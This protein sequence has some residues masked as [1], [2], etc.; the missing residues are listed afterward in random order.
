MSILST[1]NDKNFATYVVAFQVPDGSHIIHRYKDIPVV[2]RDQSAI[3]LQPGEV[4]LN[5]QFYTMETVL[6]EAFDKT[7]TTKAIS[8]VSYNQHVGYELSKDEAIA[9][10]DSKEYNGIELIPGFADRADFLVKI[11]MPTE[12]FF[13]NPLGEIYIKAPHQTTASPVAEPGIEPVIE[14][15]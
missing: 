2:A 6:Y 14:P 10:R 5:F 11:A 13:I 8:N 9:I 1:M 12:S 15:N 7:Y 4:L 3:P